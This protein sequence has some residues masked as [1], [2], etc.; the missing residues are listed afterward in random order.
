MLLQLL[1]DQVP[2]G[3][4][5]LLL[6]RVPWK[7]IDLV[8]QL[9]TRLPRCQGFFDESNADSMGLGFRLN[10]NLTSIRIKKLNVQLTTVKISNLFTNETSIS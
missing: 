9:F 2:V 4:L 6:L 1:W 3:D 8:S 7:T 5:Y 10:L